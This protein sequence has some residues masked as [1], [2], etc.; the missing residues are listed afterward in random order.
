MVTVELSQKE[1]KYLFELQVRAA[2][3]R[4]ASGLTDHEWTE[5]ARKLCAAGNGDGK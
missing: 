1:G 5:L 2:K 4:N 3:Y